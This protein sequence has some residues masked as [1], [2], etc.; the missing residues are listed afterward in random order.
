MPQAVSPNALDGEGELVSR[1][2]WRE[3]GRANPRGAEIALYPE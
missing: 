1:W 3:E 2:T